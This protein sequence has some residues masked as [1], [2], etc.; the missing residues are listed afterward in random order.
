MHDA[1]IKIRRFVFLTHKKFSLLIVISATIMQTEVFLTQ[2][3]CDNQNDRFYSNS[4]TNNSHIITS[5]LLSEDR[6]IYIIDKKD[7]VRNSRRAQ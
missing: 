3:P 4:C 2:E 1:A 6:P 7:S 5:C